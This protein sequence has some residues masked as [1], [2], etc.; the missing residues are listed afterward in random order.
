D[1][2]RDLQSA[3][4]RKR[5]TLSDVCFESLAVNEFHDDVVVPLGFAAVEYADDPWRLDASGQPR[6]PQ[7]ALGASRV[8]R[9]VR[10]QEFDRHIQIQVPMTAFI[11]DPHPSPTDGRQN[12]AVANTSQPQVGIV[13][14][15]QTLSSPGNTLTSL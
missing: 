7:K 12:V 15:V 14:H 11:D 1:R 5:M 10:F 3:A 2:L 6:F 13:R 8:L 9:Q 4:D